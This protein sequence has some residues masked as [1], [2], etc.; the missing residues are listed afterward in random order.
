MRHKYYIHDIKAQGYLQKSVVYDP[1]ILV[2][3]FAHGTPLHGRHMY[4]TVVN[5]T[6]IR[7][8]VSLMQVQ[9]SSLQTWNIYYY[10]PLPLNLVDY[11][12]NNNNSNSSSSSSSSSDN[13]N[14]L[15]QQA[16]TSPSRF[17]ITPSQRYRLYSTLAMLE[18]RCWPCQIQVLG[19]PSR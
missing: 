9:A 2:R 17:G 7:N 19:V 14:N 6:Q 8:E 4:K 10:T 11:Y 16:S 3:N 13:N 5:T 1:R 18:R 15:K 12:N